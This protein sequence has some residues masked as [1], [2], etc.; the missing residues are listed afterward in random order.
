M[1]APAPK[2]PAPES[3]LSSLAAPP[4]VALS[5]DMTGAAACAGELSASSSGDTVVLRSWNR[6]SALE[7]RALV[8][9][10][11]SRLQSGAESRRRV[12][13]VIDRLREAFPHCD[14]TLWY[15]RVDSRLR[16][17][18]IPEIDAMR[19]ALS[20]PVVLAPAAPRLGITTK[21]GVQRRRVGRRTYSLPSSSSPSA[22]ECLLTWVPESV[23]IASSDLKHVGTAERI[24]S[25]LSN[26]RSLVLDAD[27]VGDLALAAHLLLL[28]RPH[29]PFLLVGSYGLAGLVYERWRLDTL[30]SCPTRSTS[31][32][33]LILVGSTETTSRAQADLLELTGT[34]TV[35]PWQRFVS[36]EGRALVAER[37]SQGQDVLVRLA[38][39]RVTEESTTPATAVGKSVAWLLD[40]VEPSGLVIIGGE[41]ASSVACA[42]GMVSADVL[43]EPWPATPL[44]L[45]NRA[46]R[47]PM[48]LIIKSGG[49]GNPDWL[50]LALSVLRLM[51]EARS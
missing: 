34:L 44:L 14:Q 39:R 29:Q 4:F 38:A 21:D 8:V 18:I 7:R 17:N 24:V 12:V 19:E 13:H 48:P 26:G 51:K 40:R 41:M 23:H 49:V 16:G 50:L 10:T 32:P 47:C 25:E 46:N 5:D 37:L 3:V 36:D 31:S 15:K 42:C 6:M 20:L 30:L 43:A 9:D 35:K 11:A 1:T 2:V 45:M 28:A 33:A 27:S 22:P